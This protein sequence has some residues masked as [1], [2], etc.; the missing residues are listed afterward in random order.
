MK[1][2]YVAYGSNMHLRQ[3]AY[4]CPNAILYGTGILK[5][6]RLIFRGSKTGAYAT[7][8]E[9][10]SQDV[11]VVIWQITP[12]CERSLDIYEGYPTFYQ[13]HIVTVEL[14]PGAIQGMV[15]IMDEHCQPGKPSYRYVETV[16]QGY[17]DNGFG[18]VPLSE[19]LTYNEFECN[20]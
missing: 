16:W 12:L 5:G 9:C 10:E 15:Y 13:K 18:T 17:M 7:I 2:Y 11:P 8:E 1:K 4:R 14:D 6:W 3:M 19:A 20:S